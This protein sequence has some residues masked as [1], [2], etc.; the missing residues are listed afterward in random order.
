MKSTVSISGGSTPASKTK[1]FTTCGSLPACAVMTLVLVLMALVLGASPAQAHKFKQLSIVVNQLDSAGMPDSEQRQ[2]EINDILKQCD[3]SEHRIRITIIKANTNQNPTDASG[4]PIAPDGKVS[5]NSSSWGLK[6][7]AL[8]GE[9]KNGGLKVWVANEVRSGT[10]AAAADNKVVNGVTYRNKQSCVVRSQSGINGD[11]RT[12]AHEMGHALGLPDLTDEA[13]ADNLM[14]GTRKK[15]DGKPAGT[16]LTE[17]QCKQLEEALSKLKPTETNTLDQLTN[18]PS[19]STTHTI[20]DPTNQP[21]VKETPEDIS[22]VHLDFNYYVKDLTNQTLNLDLAINAVFTGPTLPHYGV[23]IDTD[24]NPATGTNGYDI[25]IIHYPGGGSIGS[26][27]ATKYIGAAPPTPIGAGGGQFQI[28]T[29]TLSGSGETNS[30]ELAVGT[31]LSSTVPLGLFTNPPAL[32]IAP[33]VRVLVTAET[34]FLPFSTADMVGPEL[35]RTVP[36]PGPTLIVNP[37]AVAPGATVSLVGGNFSPSTDYKIL[38]DD[39]PIIRAT[40]TP[41][42]GFGT[43]F[44]APSVASD[45]YLIDAIDANG[46]VQV[47]VLRITNASVSINQGIDLFTTPPGGATRQDFSSMPLPP[48][49]FDPGSD[50]FEGTVVFQGQPL[51]TQPPGI[52]GPTDTIV[53]RS[54]GVTLPGPSNTIPIE[55][56]ALSLVS[57]NPITVTY[58]NGTNPELWNVRVNL[59][60]NAPQPRGSMTIKP[61]PCTNEG[62]TFS[63]TLPV[64]PK[65][66]F[67]RQHDFVERTLDF[68]AVFAPPVQF[69]TLDGH[70]LPFDPGFNIIHAVPGIL[71]DHDGDTN[72]PPVGPLPGSSNDFFPGLRSTHCKLLCADSPGFLKRMTH[73]QALLAA[74]GVLPAQP[75]SLDTDGDGIPDDADNCP[76]VYNPLQ[77]D[78]DYD[79]AGDACDSPPRLSIRAGPSAAVSWPTKPWC[80]NLQV[81]DKL[82]SSNNWHNVTNNPVVT[83]DEKN[84]TLPISNKL[85][86]YRLEKR[87]F[88]Y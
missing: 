71:V 2:K 80:F 14:Y 30:E 21:P 38:F 36:L 27:Q 70:W 52:F 20:V 63:A 68:G 33:I 60:S 19:M 87:A 78:A 10:N 32:Q 85:Q 88:S 45:D 62:G 84:V 31:M 9:V 8:N 74:H 25:E 46:Q 55:I 61:G 65:F 4:E 50:P 53:Q 72:T 40:T 54:A 77:E 67:T 49:F 24:N 26:W 16:G 35:V 3:D 56:V 28:S 44:T 59:S 23:W 58:S 18:T 86:I 48:G 51:G 1:V 6:E 11:A 64:M 79:G 83:N 76:T 39:I 82:P 41:T 34:N 12:W 37:L 81:T 22:S 5:G 13:D 73:E 15:K 42:G 47:G 69:Q 29:I 66:V 43:N 75:P 57:V 7:N 17:D